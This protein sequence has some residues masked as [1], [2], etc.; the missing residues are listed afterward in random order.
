MNTISQQ[1][2]Y[3]Q[4]LWILEHYKNLVV[5]HDNTTSRIREANL[6]E[7]MSKSFYK[8]LLCDAIAYNISDDLDDRMKSIIDLNNGD[9][10]FAIITILEYV[11]TEFLEDCADIGLNNT[12]H[13][14]II[15]DFTMS[16]VKA[17]ESVYLD[18]FGMASSSRFSDSEINR[19]LLD[20]ID[21]YK[22]DSS[23]NINQEMKIIYNSFK[24]FVEAYSTMVV[25]SNN[26][27]TPE[28]RDALYKTELELPS[29]K[30]KITNSNYLTQFSLI[31]SITSSSSVE[32]EFEIKFPIYPHPWFYLVYNNIFRI[33]II[34]IM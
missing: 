13:P 8:P 24:F 6:I 11:T 16:Y 26:D 22:G 28:L 1:K 2:Y 4:I 29:G 30:M 7:S 27:F 23:K 12:I 18:Q 32:T 25:G 14:V 20:I 34:N 33:I 21:N 19:K 17:N 9:K 31:V 10:D 5:V 3:Y 15:S